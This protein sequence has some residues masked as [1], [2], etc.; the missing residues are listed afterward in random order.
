GQNF[1]GGRRDRVVGA[2]E[3]GDGVKEDNY[4]ALVLHEALGLFEDHFRNL[5]MALRRLI[6]GRTDDFT[7]DG[8]LHVR[9][10]FRALVDEENDKSDFRMIDG[11]GIGDGLQHHG[12]AGARWRVD[13]AALTFADRAEQVEHTPGQV[14]L[15]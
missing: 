3:T 10:F 12:L 9:D 15:G 5:D 11:D 1:A 2:R 6:E 13:Q 7:L 8:A 14:F 4:V